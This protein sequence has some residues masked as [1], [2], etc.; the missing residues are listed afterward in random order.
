M[1]TYLILNKTRHEYVDVSGVIAPR[2][3]NFSTRW[4]W[5]VSFTHRPLYPQGKS[6]RYSLDRRLDGHQS[7][8]ARGGEG[9]NFQPLPGLEPPIIQPLAQGYPGSLL[10]KL[11]GS[12]V[13]R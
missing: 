13:L 2:I 6:P 8:F 5:V 4:S 7:R 11:H 3:L 10:E 12:P 9:K 1:K